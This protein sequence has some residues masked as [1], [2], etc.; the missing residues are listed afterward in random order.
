MM[1]DCVE[2]ALALSIL[3]ADSVRIRTEIA[4]SARVV[5]VPEWTLAEMH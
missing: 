1:I 4:D 2:S 5:G 3:N